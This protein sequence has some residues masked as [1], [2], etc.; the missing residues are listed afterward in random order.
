VPINKLL[1]ESATETG[2]HISTPVSVANITGDF[3]LKIYVSALTA[4]VRFAIEESTNSFST[5]GSLWTQNLWGNPI[6]VEG[7]LLSFAGRRESAGTTIVG[8]PNSELR[9]NLVELTPSYEFAGGI[10]YN[11]WIEY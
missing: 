5:V 6:P 1:I 3:T 9:F 2:V 10:T 7:M 4:S 8:Q 11:A